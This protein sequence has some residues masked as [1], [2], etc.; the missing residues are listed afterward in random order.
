MPVTAMNHFTVVTDD[1]DGARAFYSRVLGLVEGARPDLGFPG[2]WMYIADQAVLH[3]V[4][5]RGVPSESA[6]VIDHIAFSG[7]GLREFVARLEREGI[8]YLLR[9]QA[10]TGPWQLFFHDPSGARVELDFDA[11]EAA[12]ARDAT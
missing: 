10:G 1:L 3:I 7:E 4:A 9:R 5:G 11:T 6:G 2:A 8:E 12:P